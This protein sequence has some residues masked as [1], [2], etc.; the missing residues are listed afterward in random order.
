M[1]VADRIWGSE[2]NNNLLYVTM[3]KHIHILKANPVCLGSISL[4]KFL[5]IRQELAFKF[6]TYQ[7]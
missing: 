6:V 4:Q 7:S 2:K 5:Q 3:L 1:A